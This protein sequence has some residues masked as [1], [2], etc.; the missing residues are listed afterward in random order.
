MKFGVKIAAILL[1][2]GLATGV[3]FADNCGAGKCGGD[4]KAK[5]QKSDAS[6]CGGDMNSTKASSKCGGDMKT[7][8]T[9]CGG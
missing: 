7:K 8:A 3:A 9:K 4:M 5:T 1:G 6:K 2:F